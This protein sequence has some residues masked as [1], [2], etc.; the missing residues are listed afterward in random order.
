MPKTNTVACLILVSLTKKVLKYFN[1]VTEYLL[2]KDISLDNTWHD[3]TIEDTWALGLL[4]TRLSLI[5]I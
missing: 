4:Y 2:A 1:T 5:I 3:S